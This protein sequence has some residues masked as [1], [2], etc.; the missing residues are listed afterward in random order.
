MPP[1]TICRNS[2]S[3]NPLSPSRAGPTTNNPIAMAHHN[4]MGTKRNNS[5]NTRARYDFKLDFAR[6]SNSFW[7]PEGASREPGERSNFGNVRYARNDFR[8]DSRTCEV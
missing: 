4:Q 8:A 1:P 3:L 2:A 7:S 6:R 5:G